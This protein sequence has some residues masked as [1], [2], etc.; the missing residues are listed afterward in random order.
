[1]NIKLNS[2]GRIVIIALRIVIGGHLFFNGLIKIINPNWSA[3]AFLGGSYGVFSWMATQKTLMNLIDATNMWTLL[4]AGVLLVLGI[5]ERVAALA[6]IILLGL[7]YAAYPPFDILNQSGGNGPAFIVNALLIEMI[8]LMV[9][10]VFPTGKI[11]GM[12]RLAP[13]YKS[14]K[15][16]SRGGWPWH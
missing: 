10:L 8:A 16:N 4:M 11:F 15:T 12:G 7:Y 5:F 14:K 13:L 1:M 9:I 6:G 3:K 2:T